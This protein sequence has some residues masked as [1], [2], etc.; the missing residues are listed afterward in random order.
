MAILYDYTGEPLDVEATTVEDDSITRAK[1]SPTLRNSLYTTP[2][3]FGAVGDGVANDTQ[4]VQSAIDQGNIIVLN[5]IYRCTATINITKTNTTILGT[6]TILCDISTNNYHAL[7]CNINTSG[8]KDHIRISGINIR[9]A[10]GKVNGGIIFDHELTSGQGYMDIIIEGVNIY[11]MGFRGIALYG[12]PYNSNYVRPHFIVDKCYVVNCGNIGICTSHVSARI[13]NCY[14]EGSG[15]ENI[16]LDNGGENQI[17]IGNIL[18]GHKGGVGSIGVDE[19]NGVVI[20]NNHIY[21]KEQ[22]AWNS[23]YNAGIGFQCNTGDDT[24][25]IVS[26]NVFHGGK[27]G[28]KLGGTYKAGG[29]FTNNVFNSVGTLA[30]Y[31]KNVS[32]SIKENNLELA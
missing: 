8:D 7:R 31:D 24:N 2:E 4:A 22:S 19:E 3:M 11:G 16:T 25:V 9:Q 30:F 10:Q 21:C 5:G 17:V 29:V 32:T 27:Y 14:I 18:K 15:L 6:G 13:Q 12:G 1:L 26:G 23:E 28:I 20:A